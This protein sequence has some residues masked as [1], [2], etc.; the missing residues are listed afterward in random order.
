M[1]ALSVQELSLESAE[2][3]PS[4]ETLDFININIANVYA[5]N[6]A[7]AVNVLSVGSVANAY[8]A[9]AVVVTQY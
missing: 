3:L 7:V 4:R 9:Q 2:L 8:A 1:T 6:T 5:V